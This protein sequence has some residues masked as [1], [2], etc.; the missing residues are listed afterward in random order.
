MDS[1]ELLVRGREILDPVLLPHGFH[2]EAGPADKGSGGPF[3]RGAYVRDRHRLE[4][5]VR[6]ALGEVVYRV[7]E[8]S[9]VHE[10]LMRVIAGPRG[11]EYP[12]FSTDPLDGRGGL[13]N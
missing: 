2:F 9:I 8:T 5:S 3:A 1:T 10:E 11:A 7:G 13:T 12:G 4:F 6:W